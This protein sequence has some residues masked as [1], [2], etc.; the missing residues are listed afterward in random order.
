MNE[1][2]A[3]SE[4]FVIEDDAQTPKEGTLAW[5]ELQPHTTVLGLELPDVHRVP[6][7]AE[8]APDDG[9]NCRVIRPDGERCGAP[10][11]RAYGVCLVHA[12]GGAQDHVAMS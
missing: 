5:L 1:F 8:L 9:R 4:D 12:G 7:D 6:A 10:R 11:T 3:K 2:P